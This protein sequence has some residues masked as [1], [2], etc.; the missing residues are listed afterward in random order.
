MNSIRLNSFNIYYSKPSRQS[1]QYSMIYIYP[2]VIS[3]FQN[4]TASYLEQYQNNFPISNEINE[5]ILHTKVHH[6]FLLFNFIT[7]SMQLKCK[8]AHCIWSR[9]ILPQLNRLSIRDIMR[10]MMFP[11]AIALPWGNSGV[12]M[13]KV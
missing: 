7:F 13:E 10:S 4:K 2:T 12:S 1:E 9:Q 6:N 5:K 11:Y 3:Q 8:L